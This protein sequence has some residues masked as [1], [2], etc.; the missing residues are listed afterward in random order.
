[1]RLRKQRDI[2]RVL[3]SKIYST[4]GVCSTRMHI[5]LCSP[6]EIAKGETR[7][8]IVILAFRRLPTFLATTAIHPG[9]AA[10]SISRG[11]RITRME[12]RI[13]IRLVSANACRRGNHKP[14]SWHVAAPA[15]RGRRNVERAEGD[16]RSERLIGDGRDGGAGFHE[17]RDP[18]L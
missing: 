17:F 6:E 9:R 15:E 8:R 4:R 7:T 11:L 3:K 12:D 1:M 2:S 5:Q 18:I 14:F 13:Y 16:D 10:K